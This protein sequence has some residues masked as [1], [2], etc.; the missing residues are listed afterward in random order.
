MERLFPSILRR[1]VGMVTIFLF[2]IAFLLES[3]NCLQEI[4]VGAAMLDINNASSI[5]SVQTLGG[6]INLAFED[7]RKDGLLGKN[8]EIR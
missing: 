3:S 7:C 5:L 2:Y 8:Y 6:G 1:I 4:K